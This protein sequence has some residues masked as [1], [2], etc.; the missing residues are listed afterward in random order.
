MFALQTDQ[1]HEVVAFPALSA[2]PFAIETD[3]VKFDLSVLITEETDG[4]VVLAKS[5]M[6]LFE[7]AT[8]ERLV[9]RFQALLG[10][11]VADPGRPLSEL[12][13]GDERS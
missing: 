10:G 4:L 11:I 13:L 2:T 9:D 8:I 12:P 5:S 1:R 6:D 3:D 7:R